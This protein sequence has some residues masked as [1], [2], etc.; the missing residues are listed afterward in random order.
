MKLSA[1]QTARLFLLFAVLF[2]CTVP[3][4]RAQVWEDFS[5]GDFTHNPAWEGDTHAFRINSSLQLQLYTDHADSVQ[6]SFPYTLPTSDTVVWEAWLKLSF[7]PTAN[8]YALLV[9]YAD[10]SLPTEASQWLALAVSDP[11]A[12]DHRIALYQDGQLLL[13]LPYA[14]RN[15][16]NPLRFKLQ[17]V[18]RQQFDIW[19]DTV[20]NVDSADYTYAGTATA[21]ASIPEAVHFGFYAR[22]TASRSH[23]FYLDDIGINK[24]AGGTTPTYHRPLHAGDI[25]VN[26]ILFNPEPGGADYVELVN[27]GDS[28]IDLSQLRLAKVDGETVTRLYAIADSGSIAAGD[29][30][31][32]TTDADY[33]KQHYTVRYPAKMLE[34]GSMPSYNDASGSVVVTTVDTLVLDR[35]DYSESMHSPLLR[36]KEGVALERRSLQAPTQESTNWY[37]ASSTSGYGTPTYANSQSR[38]FLF[39]DDDFHIENTLFSPDGDGYNDLLDIT[40]RLQQCDLSCNID[41]YDAHGRLVRHLQRGVL[42]GCEGVVTWDGTDESGKRCLRG[43]YLVVA[44]AYNTS[45]TRQSWRRRVTLVTN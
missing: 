33:V 23:H 18:G 39:V 45:G 8:N 17:M 10:N 4:A 41:I 16:T 31:V 7:A 24:A 6:V 35:F 36:N 3:V 42:L 1:R 21:V 2:V 25:L 26:E 40:Y 34:V 19:I 32:V 28:S 30:L 44:E 11:T 14:P 13:Q 15:N 12:A 20:G 43:N 22:F 38:E 27:P 37:S 5:D 9:F 29:Y